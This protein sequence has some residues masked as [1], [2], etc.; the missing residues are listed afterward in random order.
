MINTSRLLLSAAVCGIIGFGA[1]QANA[2][3]VDVGGT[4]STS[5]SLN[6]APPVDFDFASVDFAAI[7]SG[8]VTYGPDGVAD[9]SGA[10]GINASG[11]PVPGQISITEGTETLD[12]S[13]D[14]TATLTDAGGVEITVSEIVWD[15]AAVAPNYAAA[16]NTCGGLGAGV[17]S[18]DTTVDT[19]PVINI[20]AELTFDSNELVPS[21]SSTYDTSTGTGDPITFRIVVQ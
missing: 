18:I 8:A 12:V 10:T 5:P 6:I 14:L 21:G 15:I 1:I 17:V 9:D 19:N 3:D 16:A 20:G 7:H 4:L 11:T 13:C 2:A